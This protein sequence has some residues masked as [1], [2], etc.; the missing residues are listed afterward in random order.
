MKAP[1]ALASSKHDK[2]QWGVVMF[3][4]EGALYRCKKSLVRVCLLNIAGYINKSREDRARAG[5]VCGGVR[6]IE[7]GPKILERKKR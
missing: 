7:V 4:R 2:R 5:G 3:R 1:G 6:V